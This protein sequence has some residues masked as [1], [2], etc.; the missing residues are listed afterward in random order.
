MNFQWTIKTRLILALTVTGLL[1]T[2]VVGILAYR[3]SAEDLRETSYQKLD[4]ALSSRSL[5]ISDYFKNIENQIKSWSSVSGSAMAAFRDAYKALE[6]LGMKETSRELHNYYADEFV[7]NI[8]KL[9]TVKAPGRAADYIPQ[10][11]I[12]R[13]LQHNYIAVNPNERGSK[14]QLEVHDDST[15][16]AKAHRRFHSKISYYRE[17]FG[18]YDIFLV[19]LKGNL[20]YSVYKETDYATNLLNGPYANSGISEAFRMGLKLKDKNDV[21][22]VDFKPYEPSYNGAASF[23]SSPVVDDTSG[24]VIGIAIFQMPVDVI[25]H[26]MTGEEKWKDDGLGETGHLYLVGKDGIMRSNDRVLIESPKKYRELLEA[27]GVAPGFLEAIVDGGSTIGLRQVEKEL[28]DNFSENSA[29]TH[30]LKTNAKGERVMMSI[31]PLAYDGL[32]WYVVAAMHEDEVLASANALFSKML[33]ACGL[34]LVVIVIVSVFLGQAIAMPIRRVAESLKEISEGEADLTLRLKSRD[35]SEDEADLLGRYFNAFVQNLQT[36]ISSICEHQQGIERQSDSSAKVV[37]SSRV[38]STE[39]SQLAGQSA[40]SI[41]KINQ[42]IGS[43]ASGS[44]EIGASLKG[45]AAAVSQISSTIREMAGQCSGGAEKAKGAEA[46]AQSSLEVME[47][48]NDESTKIG[49]VVD[50]I[51]DIA[52]KTDLLALNATIEAASAGEAG[53]GFAVV[54]GEIKELSRQTQNATGEISQLIEAIRTRAGEADQSSQAIMEIISE[55]NEIMAGIAAGVEE[56]AVTGEEIDGNLQEVSTSVDE[57]TRSITEI[58]TESVD[59]G[60]SFQ[61]LNELSEEGASNSEVSATSAKELEA[62]SEELQ[63]QVQRFRL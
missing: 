50:T 42:N 17:S 52:Q 28:S 49:S 61:R 32:D 9:E 46:K 31:K 15:A 22:L 39:L 11:P 53:K 14:D 20:V 3:T 59:L 57:V 1:T 29:I 55:L 16:Y 36:I 4:V 38:S 44:E 23:I 7:P 43:L 54:A 27:E 6:P 19:D 24:D 45:V 2:L 13:Y 34:V 40:G 35:G 30:A 21:A 5:N 48:L 25:N 12:G 33:W 41:E 62:I 26:V 58:S 51:D 47:K 10:T 60:T 18:Y 63:Q 37:E 8:R 56:T